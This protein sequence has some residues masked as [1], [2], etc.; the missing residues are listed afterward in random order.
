MGSVA[1][2]E[3]LAFW[4]GRPGEAGHGSPRAE[5][6]RKD[7]ALDSLIHHRFGATLQAALRQLMEDHP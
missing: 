6:F 2:A 1:P 7:P 3:V 4:F 5:W